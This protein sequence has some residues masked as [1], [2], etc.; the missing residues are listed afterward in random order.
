MEKII[1]VRL[2]NSEL[3]FGGNQRWFCEETFKKYGCGL[4]SCTD[5]LLFK[6]AEGCE[7]E[8]SEYMDFAEALSE[9]YLK[10]RNAVGLNGLS[11]A[12]G[13]NRYFKKNSLPYR[14]KWGTG[15]RKML[16]EIERMLEMGFPVCMSVGPNLYGK[17]NVGMTFYQNDSEACPERVGVNGHYVTVTGVVKNEKGTWLEISSW[18]KRFYVS[19]SEYLNYK[20]KFLTFFSNILVINKR[21]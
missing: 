9:K 8:K 17:K 2:E 3:S 1:K 16:S 6:T 14:A 4:V 10:V 20:R 11:M 18:G 12:R 19:F 13:M 7:I 5:I 15:R 21:K